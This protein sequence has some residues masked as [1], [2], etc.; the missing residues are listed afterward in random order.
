MR[1]AKQTTV[2]AMLISVGFVAVCS[3]GRMKMLI[4]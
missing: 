3:A 4:E 2:I 1:N